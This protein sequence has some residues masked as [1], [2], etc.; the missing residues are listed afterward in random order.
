MHGRLC[1]EKS[2]AKLLLFFDIH[3][4][5]EKKMQNNFIL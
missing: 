2:G 4:K 5:K 1:A 3:K